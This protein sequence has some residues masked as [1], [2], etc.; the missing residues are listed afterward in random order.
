[1][2]DWSPSRW[3]GVFDEQSARFRAAVGAA[4]LGARV[5]SCPGW[6]FTELTSHVARF[7]QQVTTYLASG[8]TVALRLDPPRAVADPL[9]HLDAELARAAEVLATTPGN[10]PVWTFSP[11]APDL[12]WVWHR[13]AAHELN[14]RRWD[15]QAT[16]R[17]LDP[18]D[19]DQ[20]IDSLDELLGTLL[21]AR[22]LG[23]EPPEY[24]G[25]AVVATEEGRAWFVRLV[26]G[27]VPE[28]RPADPGEPADARL[29]GRAATLLYQLRGRMRLSGTGDERVLKGLRMS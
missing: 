20:A 1:M 8:S 15:A 28:V 4:D 18:T 22:Q 24:Q 7:C 19:P 17:T 25:S 10:R 29:H 5:P 23:D 6:T 3:T 26:P 16:L 12:A 27:Q 13:R 11:A 21:A 9:A 14:L 2:S